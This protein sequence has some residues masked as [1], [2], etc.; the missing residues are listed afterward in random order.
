MPIWHVLKNA[1]GNVLYQVKA[2]CINL[3]K[4]SG[5]IL[6]CETLHRGSFLRESIF[7]FNQNKLKQEQI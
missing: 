5:V 3:L 4:R 2:D 7:M 6:H 1:P